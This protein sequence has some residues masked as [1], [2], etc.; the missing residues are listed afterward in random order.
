[1]VG[2]H[3]MYSGAQSG[4]NSCVPGSFNTKHLT[5]PLNGNSNL[6]TTHLP[7]SPW[8]MNTRSDIGEHNEDCELKRTSQERLFHAWN[9][10]K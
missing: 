2:R 10:Q 4:H 3:C 5:K 9:N 7:L 8:I 6:W 1:M